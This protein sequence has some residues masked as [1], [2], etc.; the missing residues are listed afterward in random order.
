[1]ASPRDRHEDDYQLESQMY[2]RALDHGSFVRL[3][4]EAQTPVVTV[5]TNR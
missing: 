3:Q 1:M 5:V 2:S 4:H